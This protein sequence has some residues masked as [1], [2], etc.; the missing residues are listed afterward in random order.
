[1][2]VLD[3]IQVGCSLV[4]DIEAVYKL[5]FHMVFVVAGEN[6]KDEKLKCRF[7]KCGVTLTIGGCDCICQSG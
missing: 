4:V 7:S 2:V 6:E 1:M 3:R 5:A